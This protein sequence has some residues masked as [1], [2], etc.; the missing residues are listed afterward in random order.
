MGGGNKA[1]WSLRMQ[2]E[3]PGAS[4]FQNMYSLAIAHKAFTPEG[5]IADEMLSMRFEEN[6]IGFMSLV[7]T[8]KHYP[9]TKKARVEFFGEKTDSV[10]ERVE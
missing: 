3:H 2:L 4:V 7:K 8:A 1:L 10:T 6:L 5:G 9:C